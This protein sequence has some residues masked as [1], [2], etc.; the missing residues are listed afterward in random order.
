M[1][2]ACLP[3]SNDGLRAYTFAGQAGRMLDERLARLVA[4]ACG[5]PH[6]VL[7]IGPEFLAAYPSLVDRTVLATDGS[8]GATGAHEIYLNGLARHVAPVRL[9][10]NFGSEVLRGMS[11][12][13]PLGLARGILARDVAAAVEGASTVHPV[14]SAHPVA[15]AVFCE[16]PSGLFGSLAAGRSQVTF[17]TPYLDNELVAL[18]FRAPGVSR[19]SPMASLEVVR[20][21]AA[22]SRI[23]TDRGILLND[24][25]PLAWARRMFAEVTFKLDY[26]YTEGLPG[27]L[28]PIEPG[29]RLMSQAGLLGRHKYL[30]YRRWFQRELASYVREVV[31]DPRTLRMSWWNAQALE[32]ML[33]DHVGGRENY[34]KELNA[35]LTLEAVERLLLRAES[36]ELKEVVA[37]L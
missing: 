15:R 20:R 11:T 1:I 25:A 8:F 14:S 34:V 30:P 7:R 3:V 16:I 36:L 28:R 35:V 31:T 13:K 26:L 24:A 9:T 27:W 32:P 6:E 21:N 10:G 33:Q 12:F 2:A 23:P 19:H 4:D 18:A 37:S 22:L 5:L 17:R 29:F